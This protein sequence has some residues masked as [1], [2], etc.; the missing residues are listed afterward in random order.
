MINTLSVVKRPGRLKSSGRESH[1]FRS[2]QGP[3]VLIIMYLVV[4]YI[5]RVIISDD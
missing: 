4:Y 5:N 2:L 3:C 1:S